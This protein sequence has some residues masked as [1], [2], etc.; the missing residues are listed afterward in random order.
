MTILFV[1]DDPLVLEHVASLLT[2]FF[3]KVLTAVT[4][5]EAYNL[6]EYESPDIILSDLEMPQMDGIE[7][8][9]IIRMKNQTIPI[10]VLS[11]YSDQNILLKAANAQIDGY[12]VKPIEFKTL[13]DALQKILPKLS[14]KQQIYTFENGLTY[15][16]L[17][18]ELFKE[19][20]PIILGKK[21]KMLLKLFINNKNRVIEKDELIS[22]IWVHED[23]SESALKNLLNR[24]RSKIG[25]ELIISIKG[26]GWR[27]NTVL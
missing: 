18:E 17:S 14:E 13:L 1:E 4:G 23:I 25:F 19:N 8:F 6:Y 21:E 15:N 5:E 11:A 24:L 26:S 7:L 20:K 10:I 16:S 27:L 9:K 3:K 12:I 22:H 2:I